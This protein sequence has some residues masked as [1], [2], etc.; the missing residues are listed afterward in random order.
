MK[1]L[2]WEKEYEIGIKQ[3]DEEHKI[4][5]VLINQLLKIFSN[6]EFKTEFH[7]IYAT[8]MQYSAIHFENEEKMMRSVYYPQ[9][10]LHKNQ[11]KEYM[12][13]M[14]NFANM[15]LSGDSVLFEFQRFVQ[16]WFEGHIMV[17]D[18]KYIPYIQNGKIPE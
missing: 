9:F 2:G 17:S 1:V 7:K 15:Y 10:I 4:M 3:F 18:K 8:L 14:D 11:H 16:R 13:K 12:R 6:E 5:F